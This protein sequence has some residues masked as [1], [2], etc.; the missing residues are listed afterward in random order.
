MRVH[1]DIMVALDKKLDV[2][3][4][5]LDLRAAFETIDHEN[6]LHCSKF[7]FGFTGTSWDSSGCI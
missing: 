5:L 2:L 3:L 4:L 6:L 1:D 7:V